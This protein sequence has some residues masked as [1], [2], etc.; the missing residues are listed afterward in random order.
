MN[1]HQVNLN[2]VTS[3]LHDTQPTVE[4]G[5]R[6]KNEVRSWK[7]NTTGQTMDG[8][9]L[10]ALRQDRTSPSGYRYMNWERAVPSKQFVLPRET[11]GVGETR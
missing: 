7:K 2:N 11:H 4:A 9:P 6:T 3:S 8:A 10:T 5:E 1:T